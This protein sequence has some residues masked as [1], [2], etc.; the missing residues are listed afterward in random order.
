M[1]YSLW[2]GAT[3]EAEKTAFK[4]PADHKVLDTIYAV[5]MQPIYTWTDWRQ[6]ASVI[7]Q[8]LCLAK[9]LSDT[10]S[11]SSGQTPGKIVHPQPGFGL[12]EK[13]QKLYKDTCPLVSFWRWNLSN[14]LQQFS[15]YRTAIFPTRKVSILN[16]MKLIYLWRKK[17]SSSLM[18]AKVNGSLAI[19]M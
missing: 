8:V 16:H 2:K 5:T 17:A 10:A 19:T 13:K 4:V 15:D 1:T 6:I 11:S 9:H 12:A 14:V 3:R 18:I 7:Q